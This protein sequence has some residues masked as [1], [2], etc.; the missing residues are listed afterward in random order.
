QTSTHQQLANLIGIL[1]LAAIVTASVVILRRNVR[2]KQGDTVG[3]ERLGG[4]LFLIFLAM[5]ALRAHHL[6]SSG[7]LANAILALSWAFLISSFARI[8]YFGLEPFVRRRDPHTLVGWARL[9]SGKV[10]DPLVG[11]DVL[12]GTTYGVL[13][14]I[15]ES[16]DNFVLPLF[17]GLP[18]EPSAP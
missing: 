7:E 9:I 12:I 6:A 17:G 4:F 14:A 13:L 10:R 11:R 2:S 18:P 15:F 3:S 16:C 1:V 8:L 5:W